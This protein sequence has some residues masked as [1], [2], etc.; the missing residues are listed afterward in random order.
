VRRDR[1]AVYAKRTF[2]LLVPE[3]S[4]VTFAFV[5]PR[6]CGASSTPCWCG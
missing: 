4:E 6:E 5:M 2:D 3:M 1:Q